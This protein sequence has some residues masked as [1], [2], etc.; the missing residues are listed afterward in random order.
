VIVGIVTASGACNP[1]TTRPLFQPYPTAL[2]GAVAA[3][4]PRV[5]PEVAAWLEASGLP[6][7]FQSVRD[8]FVETR[9]QRA[10]EV[11][12]A[13]RALPVKVRVWVD[14]GPPGS[15]MLVVEA[16]YRPLVDPSRPPRELERPVPDAHPA[17]A[18]PATLIEA[19][20][21]RFGTPPGSG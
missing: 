1:A 11:D 15:S 18:L 14:P 8:G 16:V 5:V 10:A 21:K 2:A 4:R 9:W 19:M 13:Q 6:V 17:A 20:R 3:A 12:T 7:E